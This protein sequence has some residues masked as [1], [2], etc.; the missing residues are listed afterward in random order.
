VPAQERLR[1]Y[2]QLMTPAP[3]EQARER[4]K[5]STISRPE[6]RTPLSPAENGQLMSQHE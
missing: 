6:R 1:R 4:G 5:I 3:R 2:E